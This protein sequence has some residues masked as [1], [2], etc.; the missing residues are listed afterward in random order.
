MYVHTLYIYREIYTLSVYI[1]IYTYYIQIYTLGSGIVAK[2]R[3][4]HE[5]T[6]RGM[7]KVGLWVGLNDV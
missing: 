1:Y 3:N 6:I 2:A 7:H 5:Q 4:Y